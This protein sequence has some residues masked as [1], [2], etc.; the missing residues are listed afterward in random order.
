MNEDSGILEYRLE[1]LEEQQNVRNGCNEIKASF[2]ATFHL[3]FA[4]AQDVRLLGK[5]KAFVQEGFF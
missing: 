4:R 2:V 1:I 3:S 5:Q